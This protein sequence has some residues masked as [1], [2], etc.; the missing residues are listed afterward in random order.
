MAPLGTRFLTWLRGG[1][2]P[3]RVVG[4]EELGTPI[5]RVE[6]E[7]PASEPGSGD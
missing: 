3:G 5:L 7:K 2:E 4:L 6:W 1:S